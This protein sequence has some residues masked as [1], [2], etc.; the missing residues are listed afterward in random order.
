MSP[1]QEQEEQSSTR[2]RSWRSWQEVFLTC[3]ADRQSRDSRAADS[4][5]HL[6]LSTHNCAVTKSLIRMFIYMS[7]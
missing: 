7:R 6:P 2:S 3:V 5:T 1:T 4:D